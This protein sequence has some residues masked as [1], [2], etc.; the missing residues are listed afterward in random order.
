MERGF[1][2]LI[3]VIILAR[4]LYNMC[5]AFYNIFDH[6]EWED[7]SKLNL[8]AK[9]VNIKTEKV[10]YTKNG[11]KYKTTVSFSDGFNFITHKTNR[12]DSFFSYQISIDESLQAE[13]IS[14]AVLSH[15]K[16]V[17]N[18]GVDK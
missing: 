15:E 2:F 14:K 17:R 9:I 16:A 11:M 10:Q 18:Y 7:Y 5:N 1:A 8:N 6:T 13:I 4:P 12:D 3:L